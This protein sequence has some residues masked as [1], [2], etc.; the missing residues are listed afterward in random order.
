MF[1]L[2]NVITSEAMPQL[3]LR[4]LPPLV[5]GSDN[6][7]ASSSSSVFL[8]GD[9]RLSYP[10]EAVAAALMQRHLLLSTSAAVTSSS[11][12]GAQL[13][14][15][16]PLLSHDSALALADK[17]RVSRVRARSL[18]EIKAFSLLRART[19]AST[20]SFALKVVPFPFFPSSSKPH[21]SSL[22]PLNHPPPPLPQKLS[23]CQCWLEHGGRP[24]P[25]DRPLGASLIENDSRSCCSQNNNNNN[26]N[27][28]LFPSVSVSCRLRALGGGGDGGSTGAE[29]RSSYLE[30]Y[31]SAKPDAIDPALAAATRATACALSGGPLR[32]PLVAD[33]LG[34]LFTKE[35]VLSGLVARSLP[36][37]LAHI[38]SIRHV[39]DARMTE[40]ESGAR[41][42]EG[43]GAGGGGGE[44]E[45]ASGGK[46]P[47]G[48]DALAP[49]FCCPITGIH[50]NGRNRFL[51]LRPSGLVVSERAV[52]VALAAVEEAAAAVEEEELS[53]RKAAAAAPPASTQRS[54]GKAKKRLDLSAAIRLLPP[55]S[56]L[57]AAREELLLE[58][59]AEAAAKAEK[60]KKKSSKKRKGGWEGKEEEKEELNGNGDGVHTSNSK[61]IADD[62]AAERKR[63]IAASTAALAPAGADKEVFA[64]LFLSSKKS[65]EKE[66]FGCRATGLGRR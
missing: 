34:S 37:A 45:G 16:H 13:L 14:P 33:A 64:S 12:S 11:A 15:S 17:V 9:W 62:E 38:S 61:K 29:S 5:S 6:G 48:S 47:S 28:S 22:F 65:E 46:A 31:A 10:R 18:S 2:L 57:A 8:D 50:L 19:R 23:L 60:Q 44:R 43:E 25:S 51:L 56:G 58:R 27:A 32:P 63:R 59:A 30:M 21:L 26:N 7:A 4:G 40:I 55:L 3:L 41:E 66:S 39:F 53:R 42:G 54:E 35:A 52:R 1:F 20:D 24:L 36:P 49:R